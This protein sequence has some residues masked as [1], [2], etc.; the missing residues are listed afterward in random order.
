MTDLAAAIRDVLA[1]GGDPERAVQQQAYMKSA[2]PYRGFTKPELTRL[3]RPLLTLHP[4][5]DRESWEATVRDLWDGATH[6]EERYAALAVV[7]DRRATQWLDPDSVPLARHLLVTGAWWDLVDETAQHLVGPALLAHRPELTVV[8]RGWATDDD[9]W[10]RRAAVICQVGH[11]AETDRDL[12][13]DAVEANL[14]DPSFWLRKGIGWAL[15]DFARTDPDWVRAEVA[16]HDG[17]LS[18]LSR[19][20]ALKHLGAQR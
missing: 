15:R 8:V 14:D 17:R 6:R 18:G 7:R 1:A 4:P 13:R 10:V 12:L 20:E 11:R 3:L 19:R 2:M 9:L 16:R 5:A